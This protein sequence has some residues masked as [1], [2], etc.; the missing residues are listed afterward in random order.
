MIEVDVFWSFSFGAVFAACSA[1]SI[2][3]NIAFQT[4]F[5]S[6]PSFVYTLLFLS[7]IFAPSGLYLLWDNPGW[8]SM[9]VLGD[10]NEIHAIL[11]T[12]FAFTN[13]LLGI[14][15]YYVTYS[16][17]RSLT[18]K[19]TQSKESL[20]MSYHKYW[21]HAYTCFCAI[22]GMGYNRFM[23]PS[24]Y[25]AWRAGLQYPLTDFFTSRILF[26]LLSMGVILLPAVYIP[27]YVW[28]KGTLIRPGDKSRLTLTCIFYILQGVSVVSTLFGAY[29]VRYH[30]ND[31]KQTFIQNLWALFDN[32]NILSRDSKWSPLLGFWVAETAVMLLVYVPILFVPSIPTI[33]ATHKSQ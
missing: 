2:S 12:L 7:L 6:A 5:W 19:R 20:P 30:E 31:P 4:P 26:T 27:V 23:Y 10:K 22:L 33:A 8:E 18:L 24:D 17:I 29:I 1:G 21:I 32:G 28:L 11:P 14:I 3:K 9:F 25:V 15:G 16:K 13:V